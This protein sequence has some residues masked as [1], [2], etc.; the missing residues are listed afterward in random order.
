MPM[1]LNVSWGGW[2]RL[3][4]R[5]EGGMVDHYGIQ[6]NR[7]ILFENAGVT[8]FLIVPCGVAT[9]ITLTS[10]QILGRIRVKAATRAQK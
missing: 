10:N 3:D 2:K 1:I 4:T 5:F 9:P 8:V 7:E 6:K